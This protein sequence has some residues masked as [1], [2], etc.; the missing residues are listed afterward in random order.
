MQIPVLWPSS[1]DSISEDGTRVF[2]CASFPG[3]SRTKVLEHLFQGSPQPA[4]GLCDLKTVSNPRQAR[5]GT[6]SL[7]HYGQ[8]SYV[9]LI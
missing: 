3:E 5:D 8:V 7:E 4:C 2:T 1:A 6:P 9:S